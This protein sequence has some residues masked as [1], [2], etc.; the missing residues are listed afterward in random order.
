[1]VHVLRYE[2]VTERKLDFILCAR[3]G[4]VSRSLFV[5]KSTVLFVC[6]APIFCAGCKSSDPSEYN[7]RGL[8]RD[9]RPEADA[10]IESDTYHESTT[11]KQEWKIKIK[12]KYVWTIHFES[13]CIYTSCV[14]S[15]DFLANHPHVTRRQATGY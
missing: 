11:G 12:I 13:Y 7:L 2:N 8:R 4:I 9:N 14:H 3:K 15:R 10:R 6:K 5:Y 1:M